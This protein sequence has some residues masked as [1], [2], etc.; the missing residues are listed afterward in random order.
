MTRDGQ[1]YAI[2]DID[3]FTF[4]TMALFQ[5]DEIPKTKAIEEAQKNIGSNTKPVETKLISSV[6]INDTDYPLVWAIKFGDPDNK[7]VL[8]DA[9]TG[10]VLPIKSI[11]PPL[12]LG[13][14]GQLLSNPFVM[15]ALSLV[16]IG[17]IFITFFFIE[18]I[19]KVREKEGEGNQL[20]LKN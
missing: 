8:V 11:K 12:K 2:G 1:V 3:S 14:L 19:R 20:L 6:E 18:R 17:I 4:R 5:R 10:E 13:T 9:K 15:I 16:I 7:E